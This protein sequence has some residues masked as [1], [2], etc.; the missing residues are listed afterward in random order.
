MRSAYIMMTALAATG[1][2]NSA[3]YQPGLHTYAVLEQP[4]EM[5]V[6]TGQGT[7]MYAVAGEVA[8]SK[9]LEIGYALGPVVLL[10]RASEVRTDPGQGP[11]GDYNWIRQTQMEVAVGRLA[12]QWEG[13]RVQDLIGISRASSDAAQNRNP[14][15]W[16][17]YRAHGKYWRLYAQRTAV[18]RKTYGDAGLSVRLSAVH[19]DRF[20]RRRAGTSLD[21]IVVMPD[22]GNRTGVFLEPGFMF[23]VGYKGVKIGPSVSVPYR[24]NRT[25]F[26]VLP[27]SFSVN[28]SVSIPAKPPAP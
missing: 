19:A 21:Y 18:A 1:C 22:S 26:N 20:Q 2:V 6:A 16:P 5:Y 15:F 8:R 9:E 17:E 25:S 28:L 7:A 10:T 27:F 24:L 11:T 14:D 3:F 13:G 23:R 12:R 4:R